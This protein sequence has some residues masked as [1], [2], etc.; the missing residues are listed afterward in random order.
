MVPRDPAATHR[1]ASPLELFFDLVFVVAVSLSSAEL[2]HF[3]SDQ[4]AGA[5][6][7][8]YMMVFFAIWWA[9]MTFTWFAS[10]FS[11]DDWLYRLLTLV[12]MAGALVLASGTAPAMREQ[13]FLLITIGYVIMR[14]AMVAQWLRAAWSSPT[15][16]T[17][18]LRFAVGITIVQVLWVARLWLPGTAGVVG[19]VVLV[20]AEVSVPLWAESAGRTPSHPHHIAERFGLFTLI[21]LGESILASTNALIDAAGH[22]EHVGPLVSIAVCGLVLAAAMWWVYFS[23]EHH[24]RLDNLPHSLVF[25]YGHYFIFAAAGAFSA[26]IEV[27]VDVDTHGTSLEAAAAAATLTVPVAVFLVA[28]WALT[29][30]QILTPIGSAVFLVLT[31]AIGAAAFTPHAMV[32]AAVLSVA[33]VVLTEVLQPARRSGSPDA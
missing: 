12:Q 15:L 32:V 4:H 30:R 31:V 1:T 17:T 20:L 13:D 3:E 14:L 23:C 18:A 33:L 16:R 5:G 21:V 29:L 22:T 8:T 28:V 10:A 25:G 7:G 6:L 27:A 11:V 9:W 19:F 24:D 2:H 26:G